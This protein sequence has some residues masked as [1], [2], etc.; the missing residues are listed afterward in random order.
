MYY[1]ESD[2][3]QSLF[4]MNDIVRMWYVRCIYMFLAVSKILLCLILKYDLKRELN[5]YYEKTKN[6]LTFLVLCWVIHFGF[7]ILASFG[8]EFYRIRR[9]I[10][11]YLDNFPTQ[12][13]IWQLL[14]FM[15]LEFWSEFP[16]YWMAYYNIKNINFKLYLYDIM[17]SL[18]IIQF[19]DNASIFIK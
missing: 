16:L 18:N 12:Y 4:T 6:S 7:I 8:N 1:T 17:A 3:C 11:I 15:L 19:Y 2:I 10:I 13:S 5:Y 14:V 9:E